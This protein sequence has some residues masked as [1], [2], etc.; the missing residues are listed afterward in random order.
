[1]HIWFRSICLVL[2]AGVEDDVPALCSIFVNAV[3]RKSYHDQEERA[4]MG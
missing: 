2:V 4:T 3:C 1:M